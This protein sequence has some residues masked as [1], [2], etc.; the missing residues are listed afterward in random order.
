[1]KLAV[2]TDSSAVLN[3][4]SIER[5]VCPKY[6]SQHRWGKLYRRAKFDG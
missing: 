5:D 1:M 4:Q 2:I 6:S 3:V